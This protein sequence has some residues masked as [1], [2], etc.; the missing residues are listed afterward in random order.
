[1]ISAS[2]GRYLHRTTQI[3]NKF[4]ENNEKHQGL[5]CMK[6]VC[7][8]AEFNWNRRAEAVAESLNW[9]QLQK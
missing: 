4:A 3:Q 6:E 5:A 8:S 7:G 9:L 2:Q 1:M